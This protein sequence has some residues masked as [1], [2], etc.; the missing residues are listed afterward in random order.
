[1]I[2]EQKV[3]QLYKVALHEQE[4]EK[5]HRQISRYYR[6]DYIAK[7]MLKS[8]FTGTMAY[9]FMSALWVAGD[10]MNILEQ[11]SQSGIARVG[12]PVMIVYVVYMAV[13]LAATYIVYK[14]KYEESS[15]NT[16]HYELELLQLSKMYEQEE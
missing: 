14:A 3:K 8:I 1:M 10:W 2:N 16:K 11:I 15:R 4:A 12:V 6:N 7:E 9:L 5:R 13:Y